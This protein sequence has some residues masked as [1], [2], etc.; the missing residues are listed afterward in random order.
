MKKNHFINFIFFG[1][2][3][4][5]LFAFNI[6]QAQDDRFVSLIVD[7]KTS[8]IELYWKNHKN[9]LIKN[10]DN[11]KDY[12]ENKGKRLRFAMNAGMYMTDYSPLGLFIQKQ[13][14]IRKLNTGTGS[15]NFYINPNGVFYITTNKKAHICKTSEYVNDGSV[16]YATQSGPMLL[17]D[18][19]IN[20]EFT[21]GSTNVNIRNG[22]G[23][24]PN[25][26]V[27]FT[28]SKDYVN[29]Y[30]FAEYFKLKGCT[31]ALY[32]DGAISAMYLPEKN[33]EQLDGDFGVMIGITD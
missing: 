1:F 2:I 4:F 16:N 7:P 17:I 23:I 29:F 13:R 24:L 5:A 26:K 3:F 22:V 31:Q 10:F 27:I 14:T 25:N 21:K 28:I 30:D 6:A 32:L 20:A 8:N 11:L 33:W 9:E 19:K 18:G 12:L 15:T